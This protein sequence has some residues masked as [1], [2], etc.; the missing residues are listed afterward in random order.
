MVPAGDRPPCGKFFL[1]LVF[2]VELIY[3]RFP[4]KT[5]I[6]PAAPLLPHSGRMVLIDRVLSYDAQHITTETDVT[7]DNIF[8]VHDRLPAWAC[9]EIMAQAIGALAGVLAVDAGEPVRLGYLL[10]TRRLTLHHGDLP[11]P[12]TLRVEAREST[13]DAT[14]FGVFDCCLYHGEMRLAEAALNVYTPPDGHV[15]PPAV[16]RE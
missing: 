2:A 7:G 4:M 11:L 3:G 16:S 8:A 10:G 12:A 14:G 5:P 9:L 15:P 6:T 1:I 13:R